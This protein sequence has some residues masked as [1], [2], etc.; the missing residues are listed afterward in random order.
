MQGKRAEL[1]E[2]ESSLRLKK[3]ECEGEIK[4]IEEFNKKIALEVADIR[5]YLSNLERD[6][7][8]DLLILLNYYN[9]VYMY[10]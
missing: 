3:E 7:E 9:G 2:K 10:I 4:K 1:I 6:N 5:L 8:V